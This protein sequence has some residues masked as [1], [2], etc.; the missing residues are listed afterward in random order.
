MWVRTYL[1][2]YIHSYTCKF[3][4]PPYNS[5]GDYLSNSIIYLAKGNGCCCCWLGK[6][7]SVVPQRSGVQ[8]TFRQHR[9]NSFILL[10]SVT[11][12]VECANCVYSA[13]YVAFW[14]IIYVNSPGVSRLCLLHSQGRVSRTVCLVLSAVTIC[15][16]H[17]GHSAVAYATLTSAHS[18]GRWIDS[19]GLRKVVENGNFNLII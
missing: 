18:R 6:T 12:E 5:N 17:F 15:V 1:H 7:E 9:Y 8:Y 4:S 13:T 19:V 3:A 14:A 2:N 10:G 16:K 11:N